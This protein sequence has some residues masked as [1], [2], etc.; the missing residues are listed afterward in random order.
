MAAFVMIDGHR[1]FD[2]SCEHAAHRAG[3]RHRADGQ[4]DSEWTG[5]VWT[6]VCPTDDV[7]MQGRDR[8]GWLICQVCGRTYRDLVGVVR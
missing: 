2:D 4:L 6:S 7:P 8:I 1:V 5:T 3:D